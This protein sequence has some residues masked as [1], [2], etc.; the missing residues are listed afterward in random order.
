M[1]YVFDAEVALMLMHRAIITLSPH[2]QVAGFDNNVVAFQL[3]ANIL[4]K[5]S[6]QCREGPG[7][8]SETLT[9]ILLLLTYFEVSSLIMVAILPVL[10]NF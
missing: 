5:I 7:L 3:Y 10:N 2:R 8:P 1:Q 9:A 6:E 4:K